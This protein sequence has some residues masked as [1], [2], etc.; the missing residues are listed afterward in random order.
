MRG[1]L[2]HSCPT[3]PA[4]WQSE[5]NIA[6]KRK[7]SSLHFVKEF[8]RVLSK[9]VGQNQQ[10]RSL[11]FFFGG[12]WRNYQI[13]P[14]RPSWQLYWEVW[15]SGVFVAIRW[16]SW[17]MRKNAMLYRCWDILFL[18]ELS[19]LS[20]VFPLLGIQTA[21]A[22]KSPRDSDRMGSLKPVRRHE[23]VCRQTTSLC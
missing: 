10:C 17:L 4:A 21:C 13:H 1:Q 12:C 18:S 3:L 16:S 14:C 15:W 5:I 19:V 20:L 11:L 22:S 8:P 2:G 23:P 7:F 6:M 9:K